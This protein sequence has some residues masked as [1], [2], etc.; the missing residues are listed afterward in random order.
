MGTSLGSKVA[1]EHNFYCQLCKAGAPSQTQMDMHLNGKNHKAKMKRSMGGVDNGDLAE[2]E[3]RV[4]LKES[5]L[6]VVTKKA[7]PVPVGKSKLKGKS[8]FPSA[9][10]APPPQQND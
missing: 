1:N 10:A 6:A 4:N 5:I 3:K 9:A 2:I 8:I 7:N